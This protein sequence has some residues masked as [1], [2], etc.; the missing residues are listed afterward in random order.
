MAEDW[1]SCL[2]RAIP[3]SLVCGELRHSGGG[4]GGGGGG[5]A[6]AAAAVLS[7]QGCPDLGVQ[8]AEPAGAAAGGLPNAFE[9]LR[10]KPKEC[11]HPWQGSSQGQG[12]HPQRHSK[13][14]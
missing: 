14:P 2:Q 1:L 11:L 6:A 12:A 5:A 9:Y 7:P 4:G 10:V 13:D 8:V 3:Q